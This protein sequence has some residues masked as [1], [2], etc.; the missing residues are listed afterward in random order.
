MLK[1]KLELLSFE[2][3]DLSDEAICHEVLN[4]AIRSDLN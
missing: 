3:N 4:Y 1:I 2:K